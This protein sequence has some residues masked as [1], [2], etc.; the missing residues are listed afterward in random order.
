MIP[1]LTLRYAKLATAIEIA[2]NVGGDRDV[3]I[4]GREQLKKYEAAKKAKNVNKSLESSR[5]LEIVIARLRA[6]AQGS[7]RL[8][9]SVE[10]S[11]AIDEVD[12]TYPGQDAFKNYYKAVDNYEDARTS[13][14]NLLSA[15]VGGYSSIGRLELAPV[16]E[17][18]TPAE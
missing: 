11:T 3:T 10:L 2:E 12:K 5:E 14:R 18:T 9:S 8:S 15:T 7:P 1:D 4:D 13:W 16:S 6:N 17:Q